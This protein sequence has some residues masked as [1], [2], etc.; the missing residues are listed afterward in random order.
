MLNVGILQL[1]DK[2]YSN[3]EAFN[4]IASFRTVLNQFISAKWKLE[5]SQLS[6][7]NFIPT[8]TPVT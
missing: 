4:V 5:E 3:Y 1:E 6:L 7:L 2:S 8:R